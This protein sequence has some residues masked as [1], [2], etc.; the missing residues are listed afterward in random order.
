MPTAL[1]NPPSA[2]PQPQNPVEPLD[3]WFLLERDGYR[4]ERP[5]QHPLQ[6]PHFPGLTLALDAL[7]ALDPAAMLDDLQAS[8]QT[9]GRAAFVKQLQQRAQPKHEPPG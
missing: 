7:L 3:D 6:S 2:G 5:D 4:P 8:L 9:S 1:E